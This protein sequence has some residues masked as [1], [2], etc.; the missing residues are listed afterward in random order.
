MT[1]GLRAPPAKGDDDVSTQ[2]SALVCLGGACPALRLARR[3][4]V[5]GEH[6]P[7]EC[8]LST[9][10]PGS[11]G[12]KGPGALRPANSGCHSGQGGRVCACPTHDGHPHPGVPATVSYVRQKPHVG[13]TPS[14]EYAAFYR[15]SAKTA[16]WQA[17]FCTI[18]L[19]DLMATFRLS[20]VSG[21]LTDLDGKTQALAVCFP[22]S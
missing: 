10:T 22:A 17:T 7:A 2:G 13:D 6:R 20:L 9:R 21:N 11:S 12:R 3:A 19:Q 8:A 15:N 5:H 16:V 14:P 4:Y 18:Q 1:R